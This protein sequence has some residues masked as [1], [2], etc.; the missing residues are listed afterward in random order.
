MLAPFGV[1]LGA[2]LIAGALTEIVERSWLLRGAA[3]RRCSR[4]RR[5]AALGLG[6]RPRPL[7]LGVTVLGIVGETPG[8]SSGS[9]A[10]ARRER[11]RGRRLRADARRRSTPRN[12][13]E[14]PR[15]GRALHRA[16]QGGDVDRRPRAAQAHASRAA[17][18][19]TTEAALLTRGLSASS[20]VAL[21]DIDAGWPVAVRLYCKPLVLLIWLGAVVMALG[22]A[23]SLSDRR[24]RV[25]APKPARGKRRAA[26]GGVTACDARALGRL[27]LALRSRCCGAR[28]L[29]PCSPTKCCPIRRSRRARGRS[30]ASCAAWSARTSRSTIPTRRWRATCASG[31]RAAQG[32]RQRRAGARFP[33]RALRRVRAA[34]AALQLAHGAALAR[35]VRRAC[36][37]ACVLIA[38]LAGDRRPQRLPT[39]GRP[40]RRGSSAACASLSRRR[41]SSI[42]CDRCSKYRPV[43]SRFRDLTKV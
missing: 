21:G 20:I 2:V 23:L 41:A 25:G 7:G 28:R 39:S 11:S 19:P 3:R 26:A 16:A 8:A 43:F 12:G 9:H 4:G 22:G 37:S 18:L 35:A 5:P 34:A 10:E 38:V 42:A 14:L 24:L 29:A 30:R 32:R 15:D 40:H 27:L 1:G 13:P 33:G 36:W 6:H 17:D 31:A